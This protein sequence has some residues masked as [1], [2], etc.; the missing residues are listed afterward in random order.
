M[1]KYWN[2]GKQH[3]PFV[4]E[5]TYKYRKHTK[6]WKRLRAY[7]IT[8]CWLN[9]TYSPM[10]QFAF[11]WI[12]YMRL[13][14]S[15][16]DKILKHILLL[17]AFLR[18]IFF[19]ERTFEADF[20][21]LDALLTFLLKKYNL[22]PFSSVEPLILST[23]KCLLSNEAISDCNTIEI[24]LIF[25]IFIYLFDFSRICLSFSIIG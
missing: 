21:L 20:S 2:A 17:N 14:L 19:T 4:R 22:I 24:G 8:L 12:W 9:R 7:V 3:K 18:Q 11:F 5:F 10:K 16:F 13:D 23:L 25:Q 1:R 6:M 15:I